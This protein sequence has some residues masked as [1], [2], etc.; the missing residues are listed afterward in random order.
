MACFIIDFENVNSSGIQGITSLTEED[1]V[2]IFYTTKANSLTF[3]A[4]MD[5]MKSKARVEYF[6]VTSGGRNALDFQLSTYL[7]YCVCRSTEKEYYIIS[8]D[9]GFDFVKNFWNGREESGN[10]GILRTPTIK[11]ALA[12][13]R[14]RNM[15]DELLRDELIHEAYVMSSAS[16]GNISAEA[17]TATDDEKEKPAQSGKSFDYIAAAEAEMAYDLP[18]VPVMPVK[19]PVTVVPDVPQLVNTRKAEEEKQRLEEEA[20][21]VTDTPNTKEDISHE[22]EDT[23]SVPSQTEAAEETAVPSEESTAAHDGIIS[24][25]IV[26]KILDLA[27]GEAT[28]DEAVKIASFVRKASGKQAFYRSLIRLYGM[29]HGG[30]IYRKIRPEYI[31]LTRLC[32]E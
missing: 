2:L 15:E 26:L 7:G 19:P 3:A 11:K 5:I 25:R 29:E 23:P 30:S 8:N 28:A 9:T 17:V 31:N 20:V 6:P 16:E 14:A 21:S 27:A 4:H 24:D 12:D 1:S 32:T 10:V 22:A 13:I 18:E